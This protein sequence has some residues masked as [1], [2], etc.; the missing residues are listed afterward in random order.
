MNNTKAPKSF[1]R[2][3]MMNKKVSS[4]E[5]ASQASEV[6]RDPDASA[7]QK[8]LAASVL[9]PASKGKQTGAEMEKIA[10]EV[11]QNDRYAEK[12]QSLA[13]SVLSQSNKENGK[14]KQSK[15]SASPKKD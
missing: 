12:T 6:L 1:R 15:T 9:S 14:P 8:S 7:I 13:A 11:L 5:M 10:S 4:K 3:I 2:G